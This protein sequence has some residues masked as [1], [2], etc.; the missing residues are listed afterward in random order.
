MEKLTADYLN[1]IQQRQKNK[2][3]KKKLR[4]YQAVALKYAQINH[5]IPD[6]GW[7]KFFK[8]TG[9]TSAYDRATSYIKDIRNVENRK[10]IFYWAVR[11]FVKK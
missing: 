1:E 4:P 8:N 9:P 2:E 7:F 3:N 10:K 6:A 5:V 11:R